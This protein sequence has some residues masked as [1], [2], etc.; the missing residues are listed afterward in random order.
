MRIYLQT[1]VKWQMKG[2]V[3]IK[4]A[5]LSY[6]NVDLSTCLQPPSVFIE[7]PCPSGRLKSM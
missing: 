7:W 1:R 4:C 5:V 2:T 6:V 3:V